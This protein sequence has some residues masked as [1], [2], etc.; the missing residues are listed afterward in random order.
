LRINAAEGKREALERTRLILLIGGG[1]ISPSGRAC[2]KRWEMS[3]ME[4]ALE[5]VIDTLQATE[6]C[7]RVM[8]EV[9]KEEGLDVA[10][11]LAD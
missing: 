7:V 10:G 2:S 6:V 5:A 4:E 9:I 3:E 8:K 1:P 11:H